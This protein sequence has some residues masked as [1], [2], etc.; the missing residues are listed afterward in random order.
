MPYTRSSDRITLHYGAF[1]LIAHAD[2][3]ASTDLEIQVHTLRQRKRGRD[4]PDPH[5]IP[6]SRPREGIAH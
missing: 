2:Q 5:A 1:A 3:K 4:M 6:R